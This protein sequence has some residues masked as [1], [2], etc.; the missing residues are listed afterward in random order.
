MARIVGVIEVLIKIADT[1]GMIDCFMLSWV[2]KEHRRAKSVVK[3]LTHCC[4]FQSFYETHSFILDLECPN[5]F[6][7][8]ERCPEEPGISA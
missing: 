4:T 3:M 2:P 7:L 5:M 1:V 8:A 6:G